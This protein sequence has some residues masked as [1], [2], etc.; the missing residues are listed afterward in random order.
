MSDILLVVCRQGATVEDIKHC[1]D[2]GDDVNVK[3]EKGRMPIHYAAHAGS[4][5]VVQYLISRGAKVNASDDTG[6]KPIDYA[7]VKGRTE[8]VKC[9]RASG[10]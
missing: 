10:G 1:L 2:S 6:M 4:L 3:G 7:E 9:L 5:E 8:I